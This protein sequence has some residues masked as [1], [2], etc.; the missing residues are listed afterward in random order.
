MQPPVGL[1]APGAGWLDTRLSRMTKALATADLGVG[2]G[3]SI[4]EVNVEAFLDAAERL[5][6]REGAAGISTE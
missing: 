2:D 1:T 4:R 3:R 5:L 6:V